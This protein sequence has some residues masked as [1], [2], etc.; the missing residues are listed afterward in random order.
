[1]LAVSGADPVDIGHFPSNLVLMLLNQRGKTRL[2]GRL[3]HFLMRLGGWSLSPCISIVLECLHT[4][5][6]K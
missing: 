6:R 5:C 1:M 2:L 4:A 3:R